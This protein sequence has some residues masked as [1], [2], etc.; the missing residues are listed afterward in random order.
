MKENNIQKNRG[1]E[2]GGRELFNLSEVGSRSGIGRNV[3][4][5]GKPP[6]PGAGPEFLPKH[7]QVYD[8]LK[9]ELITEIGRAHV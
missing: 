1:S 4:A 8:T 2:S 7:G 6:V 9:A 3:D 5:S